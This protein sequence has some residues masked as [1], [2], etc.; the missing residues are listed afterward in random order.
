M[1]ER[2]RNEEI[3]RREEV[4]HIVGRAR[5]ERLRWFVHVIRRDQDPIKKAWREQVVGRRSRERERI[6][7]RDA[8]DRDMR[9]RGL[10]K[11]EGLDRNYWIRPVREADF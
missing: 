6:G 2:S 11:E 7:W 5:E 4:T 9:E 10:R 1:R 8:L 3:R